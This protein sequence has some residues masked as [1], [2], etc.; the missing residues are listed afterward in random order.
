M[1]HLETVAG[2]ATARSSGSNIMVMGSEREMIS[3]EVRQSFYD[4][5]GVGCGVW[6]VG[7]GV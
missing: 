3:P 7:C 4:V 1:P 5:G 6:S 2:D